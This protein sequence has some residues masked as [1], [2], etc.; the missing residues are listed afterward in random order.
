MITDTIPAIK[1]DKK[2]KIKAKISLIALVEELY[3]ATEAD[4]STQPTKK[5]QN[6]L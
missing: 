2:L 6:I 1:A 3:S 4:T 5:D